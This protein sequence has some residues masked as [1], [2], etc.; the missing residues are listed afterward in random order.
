MRTMSHDFICTYLTHIFQGWQNSG[1][2][3]G[4][5]TL[6]CCVGG[7]LQVIFWHLK[8]KKGLKYFFRMEAEFFLILCYHERHS[9]QVYKNEIFYRMYGLAVM[10]TISSSTI[11]SLIIRWNLADLGRNTSKNVYIK[12]LCNWRTWFNSF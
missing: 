6:H 3:G 12:R 2:K 5:C 11:I 8:L 1:D 7:H 4:N 10:L 9:Q